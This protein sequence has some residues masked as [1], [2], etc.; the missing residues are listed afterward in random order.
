M[1]AVP[2]RKPSKPYWEMTTKELA[3]ATKHFDR[4]FVVDE[5]RPMTPEERAEWQRIQ[6]KLR[7]S[8]A[9]RR[10]RRLS[11]QLPQYLVKQLDAL[12]KHWRFSRSEVVRMEE[13]RR[14]DR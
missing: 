7:K 11:I 2:T 4:E 12:V 1:S 5:F 14:R 9:E 13:Q 10:P 6:R 3:E 8:P